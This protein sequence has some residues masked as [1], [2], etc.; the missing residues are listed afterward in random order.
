MNTDELIVKVKRIAELADKCQ[1]YGPADALRHV[2]GE[3]NALA[4]GLEHYFTEPI[5]EEWLKAVGFKWHQL[6]RQQGKQWLLW[7]GDAIADWG[8]GHD[9]IGLEL[10]AGAWNHAEKSHNVDWFC[11]LRGDSSH[12]Y[13]R[14]LHI[15]HVRTRGEVIR[16]VEAITGLPWAPENHFYGSVRTS[17]QAERIRQERERL[18]LKFNESTPWRAREKD[19]SRGRPLLEHVDAAIKSGDAK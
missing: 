11:W 19:D 3:A 13:S 10:A 6:E 7:L 8:V 17:E 9:D 1:L 4:Q 18:D 15:R 16:F 2:I 14:F 12:R 5:T